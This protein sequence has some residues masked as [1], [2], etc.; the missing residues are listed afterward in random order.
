MRPRI[1][2]P[3]RRSSRT[4]WVYRIV[5]YL[6]VLDPK[7]WHH[8]SNLRASSTL[9]ELPEEERFLRS[10]R[11]FGMQHILQLYWRRGHQDPMHEWITLRWVQRNLRLARQRGSSGEKGLKYRNYTNLTFKYWLYFTVLC[12]QGCG[13]VGNKLADG[14]ECPKN[15][16]VDSRDMPVD[17]PKYP[18]PEDCQKFYICLSGVT[19]RE[20][21]C[22]EGTVYNEVLQKCDAP[23]N[24]PGWYVYN[25]SVLSNLFRSNSF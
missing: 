10:S 15:E 25:V 3:V 24:V 20:Q 5:S 14:F 1:Q 6:N 11:S 12:P 22:S 13:V 17:H 19:P 2:R 16:Q 4:T 8:L 7:K 9:K 21:G 18:H 23:E